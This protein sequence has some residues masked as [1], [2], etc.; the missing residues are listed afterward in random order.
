MALETPQ[1]NAFPSSIASNCGKQ[2]IGAQPL[3]CLLD[4]SGDDDDF[5]DEASKLSAGEISQ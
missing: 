3:N 5:R 2:K 1:S 4:V